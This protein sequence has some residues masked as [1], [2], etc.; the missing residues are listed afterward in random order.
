MEQT[1]EIMVANE[2]K[3][4][5][6]ATLKWIAV[7][8]MLIDHFAAAVFIVFTSHYDGQ[9]DIVCGDMLYQ[10]MRDIGRTAFPIYCFLLVEGFY[11]TKHLMKYLGRM[12]LFCL[13]S[14]VPFDLAVFDTFFSLKSQNVYFTLFL[15]LLAMTSIGYAKTK[16]EEKFMSDE[17]T[18]DERTTKYFC[19]GCISLV[20]MALAS[21]LKTDYSYYGIILIL[22]LFGLYDKK[23]MKFIVGYISMIW[24]AWCFPAFICMNYY[25]G[26]RGKQLKYFFYLFY[27]VH[28]FLLYLFRVWLLTVR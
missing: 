14:E 5:D 1:G 6:G 11:H 20:F 8:T 26:K 21:F 23:P 19:Y 16:I 24:E 2:K 7:I 4:I 15:G 27:P 10:L 9:A 28:L 18:G 3:G 22:I 13:I 25:N 17:A 12:F